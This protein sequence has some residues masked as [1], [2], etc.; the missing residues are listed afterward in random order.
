MKALVALAFLGFALPAAA[1]IR[2]GD[3]TPEPEVLKVFDDRMR[4]GARLV[5]HGTEDLAGQVDTVR[6]IDLQMGFI[7]SAD[8]ARDDIRLHCTIS[9]IT[10]D[11]IAG[12]PVSDGTCWQGNLGDVAGQWVPMAVDLTFRPNPQDDSG[13][14]GVRVIVTDEITGR[15]VYFV[16][17]FDWQGGK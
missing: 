12:A 9:F 11:S 2:M 4:M 16:P 17:S 7:T 10:P 13:T 3:M 8:V 6:K 14:T 1:E 15:E 5:F